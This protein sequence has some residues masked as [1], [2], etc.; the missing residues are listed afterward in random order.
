MPRH[1]FHRIEH[2]RRAD[3]AVADL[4]S[5]HIAPLRLKILTGSCCT[6]AVICSLEPKTA[7]GHV[8][9]QV[10]DHPV[11]RERKIYQKRA[12]VSLPCVVPR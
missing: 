12:G 4:P 3:S 1:R 2:A 6:V 7:S 11:N 5:N 8:K 9:Q 10:L